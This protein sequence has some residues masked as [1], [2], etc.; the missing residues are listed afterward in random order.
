MENLF[1]L[2]RRR[3][4]NRRIHEN[5]NFFFQIFFPC[6]AHSNDWKFFQQKKIKWQRFPWR[7]LRWWM[8]SREK[9]YS[10]LS[11]DEKSNNFYLVLVK[12][13]SS[14][15]IKI[16]DGSGFLNLMLYLLLCMINLLVQEGER[17]SFLL[18]KKPWVKNS[19]L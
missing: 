9:Q 6:R 19:W 7:A 1:T 3:V 8:F 5:W 15:P 14:G 13:C 12:L 17:R 16:I 2:D 4:F 18:K 10:Q 11:N